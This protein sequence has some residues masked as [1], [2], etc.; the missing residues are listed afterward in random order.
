[1]KSDGTESP[2]GGSGGTDSSGA[3]S[4]RNESESGLCGVGSPGSNGLIMDSMEASIGR[5]MGCGRWLGLRRRH[6]ESSCGARGAERLGN[7]DELHRKSGKLDRAR[8]CGRK[9]VGVG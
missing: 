6:R 1:M 5:F 9:S 2:S 4:S 3:T 8:M 7:R